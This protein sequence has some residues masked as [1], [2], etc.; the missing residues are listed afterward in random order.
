MSQDFGKTRWKRFG[1][2]M[3]PGIAATAAIGVGLANNALAASFSVSGQKFKVS[4]QDLQGENFAQFGSFDV[5][6]NGTPHAVA[7]SAF[8]SA[9][10]KGMC[11]SVVSEP[12]LLGL[13]LPKVTLRLEAGNSDDVNKQVIA[14]N[15]LIDLDQLSA[16]AEF[17]DINIGQDASTLKGSAT[18]NWADIQG[19]GKPSGPLGFSQTAPK[20]HLTNVKQTAWATSAGTFKLN[21]LDLKL[22][23]GDQGNGK[24]CY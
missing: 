16:D 24:E 23:V 4:A 13:K 7:I 10:I 17:T 11:Q 21:G 15:L 6:T 1:L 5:E 2:V 8:D 18:S 9:T 20:A 14:K 22:Y 12:A 19:H 3:V